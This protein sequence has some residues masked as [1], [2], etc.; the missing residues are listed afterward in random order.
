MTYRLHPVFMTHKYTSYIF[1]SVIT[2]L[3]HSWKLFIMSA[4]WFIIKRSLHCKVAG[5]S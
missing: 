1:D 5:E 2:P 3:Y 4:L